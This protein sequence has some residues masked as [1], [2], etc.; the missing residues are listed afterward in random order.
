MKIA[1]ITLI[2]AGTVARLLSSNV[3]RADSLYDYQ[4]YI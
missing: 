3:A 4:S 2:A 1:A